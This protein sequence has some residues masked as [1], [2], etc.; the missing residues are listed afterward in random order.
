MS[1]AVNKANSRQNT[2]HAPQYKR[3]RAEGRREINKALKLMRHL[4]KYPDDDTAK[5]AL[6]HL[7]EISRTTADR[8]LQKYRAAA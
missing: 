7:P 8:W 5:D 2:R 3:Y 4:R 6:K 1:G